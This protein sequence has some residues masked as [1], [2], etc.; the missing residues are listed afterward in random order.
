MSRSGIWS[1]PSSTCRG[2]AAPWVDIQS[3]NEPIP[4][5]NN[6]AYCH[7]TTQYEGQED[8]FRAVAAQH[9]FGLDE[10][11]QRSGPMEMYKVR[12]EALALA[13]KNGE[14]SYYKQFK[15][16]NLA[17]HSKFES[18]VHT[19]NADHPAEPDQQIQFTVGYGNGSFR[20]ATGDKVAGKIPRECS[21]EEIT[22]RQEHL[23]TNR[24]AM[25]N[26]G[27]WLKEE[28]LT[29]GPLNP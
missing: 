22:H 28:Y 5:F 12:G 3:A 23:P 18:I 27:A 6:P 10:M 4:V 11:M 25:A 29:S 15:A 17:L 1:P 26:F 21:P 16:E 7:Y 20:I 13:A 2:C 9:G 8:A 19:Y 14:T 24:L